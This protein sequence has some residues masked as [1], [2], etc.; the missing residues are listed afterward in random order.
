MVLV[1]IPCG[2]EQRVGRTGRCIISETDSPETVDPQWSSRALFQKRHERT[3]RRIERGNEAAA[4]IS[5]EQ[6]PAEFKPT[7]AGKGAP[8]RLT[9]SGID[10]AEVER[11]ALAD[12][13]DGR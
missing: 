11:C 3:R 8:S 9:L 2:K 13:L 5:D 6:A 7:G 10:L 1:R 4:K 12:A